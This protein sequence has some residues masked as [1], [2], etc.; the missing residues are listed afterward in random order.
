VL[1]HSKL[2]E[3]NLDVDEDIIDE[4]LKFTGNVIYGDNKSN[5]MAEARADKWKAMNEKEVFSSNS[6]RYRLPATL[7]LCKLLNL[8]STPP[9]V[10]EASFTYW[11][12]MG[13]SGWLLSP[14]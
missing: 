9:I 12:R 10:K 1:L 13:A 3:N 2:C 5:S 7:Y 14:C 6:S 4:L 11:S 8:F